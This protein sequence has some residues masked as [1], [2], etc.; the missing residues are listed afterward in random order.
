MRN[1]TFAA[2]LFFFFTQAGTAI[3]EEGAGGADPRMEVYWYTIIGGAAQPR[4]ESFIE[5][6]RN[7]LHRG[8][9]RFEVK[10]LD[11]YFRMQHRNY[12][13]NRVPIYLE[14]NTIFDENKIL[15]PSV[16]KI[17]DPGDFEIIE[18]NGNI[19]QAL[20]DNGLTY[21]QSLEAEKGFSVKLWPG[22]YEGIKKVNGL[23]PLPAR[24]PEV[25]FTFRR[26]RVAQ[27]DGG[28]CLVQKMRKDGKDVSVST[29]YFQ[30]DIV[31][32]TMTMTD[33]E[34][35]GIQGEAIKKE[36]LYFS[37]RGAKPMDVTVD[38]I[39][40]MP[41]SDSKDGWFKV[42]HDREVY[43]DFSI[44]GKLNSLEM[45]RLV[46]CIYDV[47]GAKRTNIKEYY[48]TPE[49]F[50]VHGRLK[51][52]VGHDG[53]WEYNEYEDFE[54][55]EKVKI[56]KYSSGPELPI[57]RYKEAKRVET[58]ISERSI[59]HSTFEQDKMVNEMK[60]EMSMD[61]ETGG[62]IVR[63]DVWPKKAW[64]PTT[65]Y[66]HSEIIGPKNSALNAGRVYCRERPKGMAFYYTY[67]KEGPNLIVTERFGK[68]NH[69]GVKK[70]KR[71]RVTVYD[72]DYNVVE[73]K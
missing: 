63:E 12:V 51:S 34:S 6:S 26:A 64:A 33:F 36:V 56:V 2:I 35:D 30:R 38:R 43:V 60:I 69:N 72:M 19:K 52:E 49:N 8:M 17:Y 70:S 54:G 4:Q 65:S 61:S 7:A 46:K 57:K 13:H 22:T 32:G 29:K 14:L 45:R 39:I 10:D 48:N 53:K 3:A 41:S 66:Y 11:W 23:Y 21:I 59:V 24:L 58:V 5:L 18:K 27:N 68:G 16:L 9:V 1:R 42:S 67:K 44:D 37:D 25:E 31:Q 20:L 55:A 50:Y 62:M 47:E 71:K 73:K 15:D 28:F 40:Y